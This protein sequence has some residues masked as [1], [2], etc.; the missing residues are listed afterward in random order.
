MW[1]MSTRTSLTLESS[2]EEI[3]SAVRDPDSPL[4]RALAEWVQS[5]GAEAL[6]VPS[7][8]AALRLLIRRAG[9]ALLDQALEQGYQELAT[10]LA[11]DPDWQAE[12]R[13]ARA[14]HVRRAKDLA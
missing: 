1:C 2:E 7:D 9:Q 14:R 5:N 10:N 3:V 11:N 4:H 13:A 6:A 12:N 8:A